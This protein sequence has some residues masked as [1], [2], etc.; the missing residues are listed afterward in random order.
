MPVTS[1]AAPTAC[2]AY[3]AVPG[4]PWIS[5]GSRPY[6]NVIAC[7]NVASPSTWSG[8]RW[9]RKIRLIVAGEI[10]AITSRS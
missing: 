3:A 9:L 2:R 10:P 7:T 6:G 4:G 5:S 1:A 8:C